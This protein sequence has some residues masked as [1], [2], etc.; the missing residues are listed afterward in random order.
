MHLFLTRRPPSHWL[1]KSKKIEISISI[2]F[3]VMQEK[4]WRKIA[5]LILVFNDDVSFKLKIKMFLW[6]NLIISLFPVFLCA[7]IYT[8]LPLNLNLLSY[9]TMKWY[10][11]FLTWFLQWLDERLREAEGTN[12]HYSWMMLVDAV[13]VKGI[14]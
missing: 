2:S 7:F 14:S 10:Y 1:S 5:I 4:D 8:R 3:K 6:F 13:H 9:S 11:T 12:S